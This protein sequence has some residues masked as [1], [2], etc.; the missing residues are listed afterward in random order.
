LLQ[1]A[2]R[3]T[4]DEWLGLYASPADS[5]PLWV[6]RGGCSPLHSLRLSA[7]GSQGSLGLGD[8]LGSPVFENPFPGLPVNSA[9][10][11]RFHRQN[12]SVVSSPRPPQAEILVIL[13]AN[14][15]GSC[16]GT[17]V[18]SNGPTGSPL[19][20][21]LPRWVESFSELANLC[22]T[23]LISDGVTLCPLVS[24]SMEGKLGD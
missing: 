13:R 22:P 4:K 17:L 1:F 12:S 9:G 20:H 24:P 21:T 8:L 10:G 16:S 19:W 14:E 2:A 15:F 23:Y 7:A 18:E 11:S 3:P 5:T 6:M